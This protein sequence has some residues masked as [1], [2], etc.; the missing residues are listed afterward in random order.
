MGDIMGGCGT[1]QIS[2]PEIDAL[3]DAPIRDDDPLSNFDGAD[4]GYDATP[5]A[6]FDAD[7]YV[8]PDALKDVNTDSTNDTTLGDNDI[9]WSDVF[10]DGSDE[11]IDEYVAPEE[12][13]VDSETDPADSEATADVDLPDIPSDNEQDTDETSPPLDTDGDGVEDEEDNCPL[14][15][16]ADQK[17]SDDD[18]IGDACDIE[19]CDGLDNNGDGSADEIFLELGKECSIG[20]GICYS[21]G[22]YVC[23]EDGK[24][25]ECDAEVIEPE[26]EICDGLDNN[27]DD[28]TDE[29]CACTPG[30]YDS[31]PTD[32][33]VGAC[34]SEGETYCEDGVV[35]D[36]CVPGV[37]AAND[38]TCNDV[39][40]DCDS[41]ADENYVIT[42]SFCGVG[43]CMANGLITCFG[44]AEVNSCAPGTPAPSDTTCDGI[45][46]DCD[47][48]A[49]ED[50]K[51]TSTKCG[52]GACESTGETYC[53]DGVAKDSCMPSPPASDDATCDRIDDDCDGVAD[54]DYVSTSITCGIGA[55]FATAMSACIAGVEKSACAPG[56]PAKNDAT[57]NAID[58]DC[59]G[60]TD[61]DYPPT[62]IEC[63]VGAC[64]ANGF[65]TCVGGNEIDN[66]TP[67]TP[68]PS[69]TTCD[70]IDDNCNGPADEGFVQS[71]ISCGVGACESEGETYCEESSV[72]DSC[73]PKAPA[74]V[75]INCDNI[76]DDC[77]GLKDEHY[78]PTETSCGTGACLA[79]GMLMCFG[80][81]EIDTCVEGEITGDDTDC[82][83]I[84]DNCDGLVDEG[85]ISTP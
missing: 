71:A 1:P 6:W 14:V 77:D 61:E 26:E 8:A 76:D 69:D 29:G 32:C 42:S 7:R 59:N 75:D 60:A 43:A 67:G 18:G 19:E 72:M 80:G 5:D 58:D 82:N 36:S 33:G 45:D 40:D 25:T 28:H 52:T 3:I 2:G 31:L 68:A 27:C 4:V 47:G 57:C 46:D 79:Q 37:P 53:E 78:V 30:L 83:N 17:D 66:C 21:I 48:T 24:S 34:E 70:G 15:K 62:P 41:V 16:N 84:D 23:S 22:E 55:C 51:P 9:K 73:Q 10:I 54:E 44:G 85:F 38:A 13:S 81:T 12:I 35:E 49:D 20:V 56:A 64:M 65:L 74:A 39:D 11:V 63:G 50:Y